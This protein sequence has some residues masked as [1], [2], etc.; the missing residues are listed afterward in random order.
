LVLGL[1]IV[2]AALVAAALP[3][4]HRFRLWLNMKNR[5]ARWTPPASDLRWLTR[6]AAYPVDWREHVGIIM[7]TGFGTRHRIPAWFEA[8]REV[9][10][11][12]VIAD[13][14]TKAGEQYVSA[15]DGQQVPVHDV[16]RPV[17]EQ[18]VGS[19]GDQQE[20]RVGKYQNM[21]GAIAWGDADGAQDM[22]KAFG[23]ELDAMKV[24]T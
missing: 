1:T 19:G 24:H 12:V 6:P 17:I 20:L 16:I 18:G 22:S 13:F 10:D 8:V 15:R 4:D 9:G 5:G 21:S 11:V 2:S 7:K 23:W 3:Y 14:A